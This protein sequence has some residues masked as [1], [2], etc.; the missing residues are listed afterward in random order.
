MENELQTGATIV[1]TVFMKLKLDSLMVWLL[2]ALFA[3]SVKTSVKF[4]TCARLLSHPL[5]VLL[6]VVV[7]GA[8]AQLSAGAV[9]AKD[10]ITFL[11]CRLEEPCVIC[12]NRSSKAVTNALPR[13]DHP[14]IRGA[15][16]RD[17]NLAHRLLKLKI[18]SLNR[19]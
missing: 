4:A 16:A 13:F 17:P 1:K 6:H 10:F 19:C 3:T 12:A 5:L 14:P 11:G 9:C 7:L 15:R 8:R 2:V 18:L